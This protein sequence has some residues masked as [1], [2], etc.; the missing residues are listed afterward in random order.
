MEK[1]GQ[2]PGIAIPTGEAAC[3]KIVHLSS[4]I[5]LENTIWATTK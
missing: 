2:D 1:N 3:A 5:T 4:T